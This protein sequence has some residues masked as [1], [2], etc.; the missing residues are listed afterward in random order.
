[1]EWVIA[2][3]TTRASL[4]VVTVMTTPLMDRVVDDGQYVVRVATTWVTVEVAMIAAVVE[5]VLID[6]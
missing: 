2:N 3:N 4:T 5:L 6:V 1:M